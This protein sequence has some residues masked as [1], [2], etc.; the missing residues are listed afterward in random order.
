MEA[1]LVGLASSGATTLVGLMVSDAWTAVRGRMARFL[2]RSAE[3]DDE[4][5][6]VLG[7]LE[8]SRAE[9]TTARADGDNGLAR[10]VEAQ[11]RIRLRRLLA[12]DPGAAA[13]LRALLDELA[14]PRDEGRYEVVHN[15]VS[16]GRQNVVV[17]GRDFSRLT[18]G[19]RGGPPA[20]PGPGGR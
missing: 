15:E 13:E 2:S 3:G 10:D 11:W 9:L 16:G 1:E 5:E 19:G 4:N 6:T 14:P 8:S 12:A 20:E 18:F 7:E 17:Q